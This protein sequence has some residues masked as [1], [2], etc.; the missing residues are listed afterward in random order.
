[1]DPD[2]V[3]A[4]SNID[5]GTNAGDV[6]NARDLTPAE[7]ARSFIP[8]SA[9]YDLLSDAHCVLEGPRGSGKT[10]LLKM[11]TPEAIAAWS[12]TDYEID[13]NVGFIGVFVPA[14]VRWAKQ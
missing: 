4:M 14:D 8:P 5:A 3:L 13:R 2:G 6:F 11:L 9:F 1:M 12:D 7:V 10:T